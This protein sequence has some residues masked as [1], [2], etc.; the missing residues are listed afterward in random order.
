[1]AYAVSNLV[2]DDSRAIGEQRGIYTGADQV[3]DLWEWLADLWESVRI[4]IDEMIA[5]GD[6]VVVPHTSHVRGRDGIAVKGRTTW[7][8]A[9]RDGRIERI[10]LYQD[11][12]EALEA[13]GLD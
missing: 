12:Q 9:L 8:F 1:L 2:F 4:E 10:V 3:R 5:G 7:L 13:A 11:K 6:H